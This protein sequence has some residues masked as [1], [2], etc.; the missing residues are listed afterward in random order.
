MGDLSRRS[1]FLVTITVVF[2]FT[3]IN[4]VIMAAFSG[5]VDEK[6]FECPVSL[7]PLHEAVRLS[8]CMH[9][10]NENIAKKL[11]G[12]MSAPNKAPCPICRT[13]IKGYRPDIS[14]RN[15]VKRA[16]GG[17]SGASAHIE[18]LQNE[19]PPFPGIKTRF[20]CCG[21]MDRWW[22]PLQYGGGL[23]RQLTFLR[24]TEGATFENFDLFGYEDGSLEL[25]VRPRVISDIAL[26]SV[27]YGGVPESIRVYMSHYGF[28]YSPA[29]GV[30]AAKDPASVKR[31]FNLL[32]KNSEIPEPFLSELRRIVSRYAK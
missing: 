3:N 6:E 18:E 11:F 26:Y 12:G 2:V 13:E 30:F 8:P 17:E 9:R 28:S 19:E 1:G 29:A 14:F 31:L 32:V 4:G 25:E 15:V 23:C 22:S 16:L 10:L 27:R 24:E 7:E 21:S 5:R 20:A